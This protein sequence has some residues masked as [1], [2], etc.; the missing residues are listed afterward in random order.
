M[1]TRSIESLHERLHA[2]NGELLKLE[3]LRGQES[4]SVHLRAD[5]PPER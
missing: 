5:G 3:V 4:R 1:E 2:A